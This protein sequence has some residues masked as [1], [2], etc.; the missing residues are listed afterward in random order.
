MPVAEID[1]LRLYYRLDG[2]EDAPVVVL[3]SSLGEALEMWNPQIPTLSERFRVLRYDT[4]GHGRSSVPSGPYTIERLGRDVIDLLDAL[5]IERAHFCGLSLGGM[6]GIWLGS[7]AAERLD[8]L[9]LCNTAAKLG[10]PEDWDA[11]IRQ[12]SEGGMNALIGATMERWFTPEFRERERAEC[13]AIQAMLNVTD[14]AGYAA[15]CAAIRDMDQR[16]DLVRIG[17]PTLVIA[18]R[19]DPVT[20]PDAMRALADEIPE[21]ERVTLDAAHLSNVEAA[22]EFTRSLIGFLD[23]AAV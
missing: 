6:T 17:V 7:H 14:P 8:R 19:H 16:A 9:V 18:G 11:R 12:V 22:D 23:R 5:D 20:P 2:P 3:S 15:C 21:A 10:T 4:R 1:D 13:T